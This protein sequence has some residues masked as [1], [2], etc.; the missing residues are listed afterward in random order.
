MFSNHR[1]TIGVFLNRAR[2]EFQNLL[3]KG[4]ITEA[5]KKGYNV[6]IFS[7]FGNYGENEKYYE[8]EKQ[9]YQLPDYENLDGVILALDTMEEM[10]TRRVIL[11][12]VQRR[13][14]CPVI[15]VREAVE[16]CNNLLVDNKASTEE[17]T[18]HFLEEHGLTRLCFMT[19]PEDRWDAIERLDGFRK[20]MEEYQLPVEE[21]QIFYGDFWTN[22]GKQACDWFLNDQPMPQ[23]ILCA[24]D[25]MAVAVA[26]ELIHRGIRI[27][28][29]I[30]VSGYD[31]LDDALKFTPSITTMMLPFYEMGSRA[32]DIID[33]KQDCPGR[34]EDYYYKAEVVTRE[35]CGCMQEDNS[36][37][38][39]MRRDEHE[40]IKVE[41]HLRMQ[42]NFMSIWLG[43]CHTINEISD[44]L[45][46]YVGNIDGFRNY[47]VAFSEN[48]KDRE[49]YS[50]Y[51]DTMELRIHIDNGGSRGHINIPFDKKELLPAEVTDESPQIWYFV[52]LHFQ[53]KTF[54]Y[55]ALRFWT[56]EVTGNL[57]LDWN[58][59]V[60]NKVQDCLVHHHIQKLVVELENMY[61]RD[62]LTGLYNR[63]GL[64]TY[65]GQIFREAKE[66][67]AT[68]FLAIIDLDGMKQ[69]NDNHGHVEG[70]FALKTVCAAIRESCTGDSIHVRSGGDE[71]VVVAEG[72]EE[73]TGLSWMKDL[74]DYLER[75][76][77]SGQKN[78]AIHASY[79]YVCRVPQEEDTME[80]Y[81]K[82]SD[83]VMYKNK[84]E[85]KKRRNEPLR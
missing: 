8:G 9:L 45:V 5:E 44:Q 34:I 18:R 54:G 69:I 40:K 3:C 29:E 32:V 43:D 61:D 20:T 46:T 57:F 7:A 53:N 22:M 11:E 13:C 25:Y 50:D 73:Q 51:S 84:I 4:V 26:S 63:R 39:K 81:V 82:E 58:V 16:G 1:K 38:V 74:E 2:S 65:G 17:I 77:E 23:A 33:E 47:C 83:E 80:I 75:F 36:E 72:V 67:Q 79:G 78:Y 35:S 70:D 55:E 76:N 85:N 62:A 42:F 59:I 15:S 14:H 41:D 66:K 49:D 68:V 71:F 48:L 52:P 37:I 6:A 30:C 27:P 56:P 64:E 28:E 31:G 21:H 12:N 10:E 24:N 60:S 19:G